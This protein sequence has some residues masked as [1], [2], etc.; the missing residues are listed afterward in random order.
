MALILVTDTNPGEARWDD[1]NAVVAPLG[2][3]LQSA[4]SI[5]T[6]G[7]FPPAGPGVDAF[8]GASITIEEAGDYQITYEATYSMVSAG[9]GGTVT[10]VFVVGLIENGV[11]LPFTPGSGVT[12]RFWD[13]MGT[14]LEAHPSGPIFN[15]AS[16]TT[17][18]TY[19]A[20]DTVGIA[21]GFPVVQPGAIILTV[22]MISRQL[23]LVKV[24]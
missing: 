1:A 15:N 20:G 17:K 13:S 10:L 2:P 6:S 19:A 3:V 22:A 24:T 5:S 14:I 21:F 23:A 9:A 8:S 12:G 7:A 11:T 16:F 4:A 18:R